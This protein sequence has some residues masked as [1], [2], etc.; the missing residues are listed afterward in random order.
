MKFVRQSSHRVILVGVGIVFALLGVLFT[1]RSGAATAFLTTEAET[2]TVR[3][4]AITVDDDVA[5]NG[6]VV[7]FAANPGGPS[8]TSMFA[9]I[10]GMKIC[11]SGQP[12]VIHGA[13]TYGQLDNPAKEVALAK[14]A[15]L[16]TLEL[17]NFEQDFQNL[18][19]MLSEDTWKRVDAFIAE[20]KRNDIHIILNLSGYHHSLKAAGKKPTADSNPNDQR[21]DWYPFLKTYA[22]ERINSK[23][24]IAY[25]NDPTILMIE[26]V[27][28]IDAPNYHAPYAGTTAE[29]TTFFR[30]ALNDLRGLDESHH[31]IS[32]GGFSYINDPNSGIDWK[33]IVANP[34]NDICGVE[35]NSGDDRNI[36][37]PAMSSYCNSIGKPWFL[38]AWS[39]CL[40]TKD[41]SFDD[42]N[43][44]P[45]DALMASHAQDMYN[46]ARNNN[47]TPPGPAVA[48]VG[49][50]FWNLGDTAYRQGNCDIGPQ[51]PLS[52][53]T[54]KANAP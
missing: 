14:S 4:P 39:S 22:T 38:A 13:T 52:L 24:G 31:I 9:K 16:N 21:S 20:A 8:D 29:V 37:V 53:A 23:T 26:L 32:T 6:Q 19:S 12:F 45:T 43:H 15:G 48:A 42:I 10:C 46:I 2:G 18:N 49:S 7:R 35:I 25:K 36:S 47:P 50:D 30:D 40:G 1:L 41:T 27:G 5:S 51:V 44:W 3:V 34:N 54:V 11:I 17:V 33:T 28:E